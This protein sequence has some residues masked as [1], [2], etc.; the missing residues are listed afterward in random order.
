MKLKL[1][2]ILLLLT[3]SAG[4]QPPAATFTLHSHQSIADPIIGFGAQMNPYLY[5]HPNWGEVDEQNVQDLERKVIELAPQHV[6]IFF[7]NKWWT[8]ESDDG[9]AKDDRRVRQSF[10]R[11][12]HLA[13]RAGATI[14]LTLWYGMF[15]EAERSAEQ[16][17]QILQ[18]LIEQ[19][20]LHTIRYVT[21]Q[22]EVNYTKITMPDYNRLYRAFDQALRRRGLREQIQIIGGDLVQEKQVAWFENL[23]EHQHE[24]LDGYAVHMY[25]DYWDTAKLVRRVSEVPQ[26][27]QALAPLGRKPLYIT[28]FGVRGH[29]DHPSHEPGHHEDGTPIADT[30]LQAM[31][32]AWFMLEAINRGY[33]TTVQWDLYTAWY[34]R[35]MPYGMI[36]GVSDG[37]P[38]KP[39]YHVLRLF[40]QTAG[41]GWHAV[42]VDGVDEACLA[43]ALRSPEEEVS[44]YL[45]NRSPASRQVHLAGLEPGQAMHALRWNRTGDGTLAADGTLQ[46]DARGVLAVELG[47]MEL[48][49]L[50]TRAG[51]DERVGE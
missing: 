8:G 5:C 41:P 30:P 37:W 36:G 38:L 11:T 47:A 16:F 35:Y 21:L 14:N 51:A 15:P 42:Q 40:T 28:E 32:V 45:L 7:L 39:A 43:A 13:Q 25:W 2:M 20:D 9:I 10:L 24:I 31:Q 23:A 48:L 34:D 19:H 44:V 18:E 12:A 6:R 46:A 49:A 4:A 1:S 27:V 29:R 50:T 26:I 3:C 22:N 33:L 17:A